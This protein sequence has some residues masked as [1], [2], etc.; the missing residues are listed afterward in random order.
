MV[1][2]G[3]G[4]VFD[5]RGTSALRQSLGGGCQ[6]SFRCARQLFSQ[7]N[8]APTSSLKTVHRVLLSG[9]VPLP[10]CRGMGAIGSPPLRRA[11]LR[12]GA[13]AGCGVA[14]RPGLPRVTRPLCLG[15]CPAQREM[16]VQEGGRPNVRRERGPTC[17]GSP[18]PCSGWPTILQLTCWVCGANSS[19]LERERAWSHQIGGPDSVI[20]LSFF[21]S[22]SLPLSRSLALSLSLSLSHPHY[23]S[24]SLSLSPSPS[25]PLPLSLSLTRT[26][27]ARAQ[28]WRVAP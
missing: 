10:R 12:G 5:E 27:G 9:V 7:F 17:R 26:D 20:S 4:A 18:P 3:G 22:A 13:A 15:W 23:I 16:T 11:R 28:R 25:L 14:S 24:L 8:T 2:L 19:T 1:V 21:L 6:K